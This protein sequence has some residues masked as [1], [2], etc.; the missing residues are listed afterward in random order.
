MLDG[1]TIRRLLSIAPLF[2]LPAACGGD[3]GVDEPCASDD[4]CQEGLVC[5]DHGGDKT[6]QEP[7]G[8]GS[9]TASST[10]TGTSTSTGMQGGG[11]EGGGSADPCAAYCACLQPTCGSFE[12]YPYSAA[13]S[14]LAACQAYTGEELGCFSAFCTQASEAVAG[15]E[16]LC[17]HA[18]G[19]AGTSEC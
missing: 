14:C 12:E 3:L 16:H 10:A 7:H 15:K 11:G 5:D 19:G 17:E 8:H 13:G 9:T 4:E 1:R 2:A 18:W 6:C